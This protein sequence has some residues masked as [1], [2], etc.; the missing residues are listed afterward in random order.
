M[1]KTKNRFR[2][3]FVYDKINNKT[4][5]FIWKGFVCYD[6]YELEG[7]VSSENQAKEIKAY[8]KENKNE[9]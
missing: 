1:K 3:E 9:V 7:K 5:C 8:E 4:T 2:Y 6:K